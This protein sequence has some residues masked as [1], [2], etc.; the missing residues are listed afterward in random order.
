MYPSFPRGQRIAWQRLQISKFPKPC[1]RVYALC[2]QR[3]WL[4]ALGIVQCVSR[5]KFDAESLDGGPTR[6]GQ[7]QRLSRHISHDCTICNLYAY[8]LTIL[9]CDPKYPI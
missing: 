6:L 8:V 4:L 7:L 2:M 5:V 3:W 1:N 9:V